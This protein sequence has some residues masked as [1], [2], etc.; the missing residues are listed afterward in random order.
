VGAFNE[1]HWMP[2][3]SPGL[4][5]DQQQMNSGGPPHVRLTGT[6]L[7]MSASQSEQTMAGMLKPQNGIASDSYANMKWQAPREQ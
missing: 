2:T 1:G 5:Q 4:S 3:T 6:G 7:G